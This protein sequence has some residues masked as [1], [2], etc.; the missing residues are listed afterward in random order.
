MSCS[1]PAVSDGQMELPQQGGVNNINNINIEPAVQQEIYYAA[2]P[3]MTGQA[4]VGRVPTPPPSSD[5]ATPVAENWS[6]FR[7]C[8][9]L[10]I[11]LIQGVTLK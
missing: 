2:R 5:A 1:D 6:A 3:S 7:F 10:L 4:A 8:F 11:M 9:M